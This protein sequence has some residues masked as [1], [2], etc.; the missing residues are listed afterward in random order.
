MQLKFLLNHLVNRCRDRS[1]IK[2]G[3]LIFFFCS[4]VSLD[5]CAKTPR[6]PLALK[7][8]NKSSLPVFK[9]MKQQQISGYVKDSLG[10]PL[11]GVSISVKGTRIRTISDNKG[12][13]HLQ[14]EAGNVL[15]FKMIGFIAR[16]MTVG[17]QNRIDVV[18]KEESSS[19]N[20]VVVVAFG[21]QKKLTTIG[22]QS[23]LKVEDLKQPVANI[24]NLIAGRVAGIVGVQRSGQPGYDNAEIYIRGISTFTNSS[25]LILVDGVERSFNNIDPEDIASFSVLK[26][27]S[28]TALY[29]VRGANGVIIIQTKKGKAG[30]TSISAQYDQG[31]TEFT[32]LPQFADGVTYMEIAN[33]AYRNSFPGDLNQSV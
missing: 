17:G 24:S 1:R 20:E 7:A 13:Y 3:I 30:E 9:S 33:E 31:I 22:A 5:V 12:S 32:R 2:H 8:Q 15:V 28:A 25:P 11:P 14:A 26:D 27:A 29:G 21:A 18:L 4:A 19:L 23:S 6:H 16:E 10:M